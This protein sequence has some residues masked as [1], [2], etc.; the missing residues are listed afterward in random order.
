MMA[1][2]ITIAP[3]SRVEGHGKVTIQLNDRNEVE[4]S[5]F[6]VVEFRGFEKFCQGRLAS[7]MPVITTR[8]C[9]ICPVSHHLASAKACDDA[10]EVAIPPAAAKL[11]ELMHMGQFIHSHALHFFYLAAPDFVLGPASDPALRNV[12][13]IAQADPELA[14]KAIRLRQIGQDTIDRVGG[15]P[16]HPVTAIPGGMSRPLS[17][18]DRFHSSKD[19]D[20]AVELA[21][22]AI[23]IGKGVYEKYADLVPKFAP[24]KTNYMGLVKNGNLE[25]Y[26]GVL[27]LI[28]QNGQR[29]EEFDPCDYL[30]YLGE[31]V[32]DWSYLK[33]PFYKKNG[34]PGGVYRVAPLARLNVADA[35]S[36]PLANKEF[37]RWK[38]LANGGAVHDTLYYH[39]A[40]LIELL[41]AVERARE[42]L[43]DDEIVS[44]DVRVKVDR[45]AGEGVGV[46]EAPR[47]TLI[48]HY[49]LDD[50]G[51][52]EKLN[53]IVATVQ[54]NPAMDMSV[55]EVAR[56]FVKGGK[57][58]E[59][60][61]N[62]VEMAV[63]CYDPCLSCA[64]HAIGHMPLVIELV[65]AAGA[66][67][68]VRE[69]SAR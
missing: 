46:I 51:K 49:W 41:Y 61:L 54:N 20:E 43:A 3:V 15:R 13:G 1:K 50:C 52:I 37:G 2:T 62:M 22:L 33:F 30:Q 23:S 66:I 12:V 27:R 44:A 21:K 25:F 11:R 4:R 7:E 10:L 35:I 5:H 65:D 31:H 48:H 39:Y 28:D 57:I 16:I 34:Y 63:R 69:R 17:H 24:I 14:K 40:R 18:E 64:T 68:D 36:T 9:G 58:E 26:D 8:I 59:G 32:E 6:H 67:V 47:G 55:N 56:E 45:K 42:L 38:K 53:L 60:A 29:L 19:M